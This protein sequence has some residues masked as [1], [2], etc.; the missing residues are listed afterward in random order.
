[1]MQSP[2]LATRHSY[3]NHRSPDLTSPPAFLHFHELRTYS[4]IIADPIKLTNMS[5]ESMTSHRHNDYVGGDASAG[6]IPGAEKATSG[7]QYNS[8]FPKSE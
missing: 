8:I 4:P 5:A 2:S 3:I 1:M 7:H 6:R